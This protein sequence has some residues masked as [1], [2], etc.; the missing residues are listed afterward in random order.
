VKAGSESPRVAAR[1]PRHHRHARRASAAPDRPGTGCNPLR[2]GRSGGPQ[3]LARPSRTRARPVPARC[4]TAPI[5]DPGVRGPGVRGA[6]AARSLAAAAS[7]PAELWVPRCGH[8]RR[9]IAP[10]AVAP[11][12]GPVMPPLPAGAP[13]EGSGPARVEPDAIRSRRSSSC[14]CDTPAPPARLRA[15]TCPEPR[16]SPAAAPGPGPS[17][18]TRDRARTHRDRGGRGIAGLVPATTPS[19]RRRRPT[20]RGGP[21]AAPLR[22]GQMRDRREP[23]GPHAPGLSRRPRSRPRRAD[24][25]R[26]PSTMPTCE[27]ATRC[28]A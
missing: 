5:A 24:N 8:A 27:R 12:P 9:P 11:R 15:S 17:I 23:M 28:R 4:D 26:A 18:E 2:E 21:C 14:T 6:D 19:R 1:A 10:I 16:R 7:D 22:P 25:H 13:G 20:L 3:N